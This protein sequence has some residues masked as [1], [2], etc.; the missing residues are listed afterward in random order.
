MCASVIAYMDPIGFA[1]ENFDAVGA[2]A[3]AT[4]EPSRADRRL[5][6]AGRRTRLDGV[7]A[8]RQALVREPDMFVRTMTEKLLTYA[9]G[10]GPKRPI[11]RW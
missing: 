2:G 9:L 5:G 7:V 3:P 10:R 4:A 1:L 6:A 11:W 8:L